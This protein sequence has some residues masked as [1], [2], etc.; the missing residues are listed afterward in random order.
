MAE[1]LYIFLLEANNT[2]VKE[3]IIDKPLTYIHLIKALKDTIIKL[4]KEKIN[5]AC[6]IFAVIH[7]I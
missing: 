5:S 6:F 4:P 1:K 3:Y 7:I 2:I